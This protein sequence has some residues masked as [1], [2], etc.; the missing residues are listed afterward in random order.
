MFQKAYEY[1]NV[2]QLRVALAGI[3]HD[4]MIRKDEGLR[5]SDEA[6]DEVDETVRDTTKR[7]RG[8][9]IKKI[10]GGSSN[11]RNTSDEWTRGPARHNDKCVRSCLL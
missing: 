2:D 6:D 8:G 11:N 7:H 5:L 3:I 1:G 4:E 9:K 10:L